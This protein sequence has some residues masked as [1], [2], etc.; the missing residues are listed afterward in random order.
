MGYADFDVHREFEEFSVQMPSEELEAA[1]DD[2]KFAF[3]MY[4]NESASSLLSRMTRPKTSWTL[5]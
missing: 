4:L 1:L 3:F 5:F 2:G